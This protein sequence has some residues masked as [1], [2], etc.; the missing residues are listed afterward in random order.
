VAS[1][2]APSGRRG[3][4]ALVPVGWRAVSVPAGPS[5]VPPLEAGQRVDVLATT[6]D[7][8]T[9]VVVES[10]IVVFVDGETGSV[11]VA[12][13]RS[14]APAVATASA[15]ASVTLALVSGR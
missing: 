5:G 14:S 2:L 10:A 7:L 1:K 12:V 4:L 9:S 15:A 3:P 13:P 6:E 11:T 8:R